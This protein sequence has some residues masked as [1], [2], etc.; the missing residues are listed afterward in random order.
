MIYAI[1]ILF[2]ATTCL[3]AF[4]K[5]DEAEAVNAEGEDSESRH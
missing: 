5:A 3:F 2:S 1:L 4:P